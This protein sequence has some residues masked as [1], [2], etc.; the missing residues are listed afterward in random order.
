MQCNNSD[1]DHHMTN[2]F[3]KGCRIPHQ[4]F[5]L[6][7]V[8]FI[9]IY[10]HPWMIIRAKWQWSI[11]WGLC[12]QSKMALSETSST[13]IVH[14]AFLVA[15]TASKG[16]RGRLGM[17]LS[18]LNEGG[19]CVGNIS[20]HTG[21]LWKIICRTMCSFHIHVFSCFY[22]RVSLPIVASAFERVPRGL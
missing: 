2:I 16:W 15:W 17:R 4:T 18:T 10:H 21:M 8:S 1:Y 13:R 22:G 3:E 6:Q 11:I 20:Q 7:L 12:G 9:P 5:Q 19:R 14:A